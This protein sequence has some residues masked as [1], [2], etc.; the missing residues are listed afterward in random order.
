MRWSVSLPARHVFINLTYPPSETRRRAT[1]K[2]R[3]QQ[4]RECAIAAGE[5]RVLRFEGTP[6]FRARLPNPHCRL[7]VEVI[8]SLTAG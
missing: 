2:I 6:T 3:E 5:H 7:G 1:L 8:P 4:S